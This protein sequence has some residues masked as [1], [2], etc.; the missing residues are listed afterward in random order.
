MTALQEYLA[1]KKFLKK[2]VLDVAKKYRKDLPPEK[3]EELLPFAEFRRRVFE[4]A[5]TNPYVRQHLQKL[6]K[7]NLPNPE[8]VGPEPTPTIHTKQHQRKQVGAR[9]AS[10]VSAGQPLRALQ[11]KP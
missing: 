7:F 4:L 11:T 9:Y 2:R 1:I 10:G 6:Y 5:R 8:V 3:Q